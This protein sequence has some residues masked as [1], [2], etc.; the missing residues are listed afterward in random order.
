MRLEDFYNDHCT[1]GS[2][3]QC[4]VGVA[5]SLDDMHLRGFVHNDIKADNITVSGP[6]SCPS[7][8]IIDF[9]LAS[10]IGEGFYFDMLGLSRDLEDQKY[11]FF[12]SPELKMGQPLYPS[13]DVFSVGALLVSVCQE[14]Q[15]PGLAQCLT[16]LMVSCMQQV[17]SFRPSLATVAARVKEL[18]AIM[19]EDKLAAPLDCRY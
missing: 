14:M 17:P 7:V 6:P 18:M 4:V 19:T 12:R 13:S 15:N 11:V 1:V 3:L 2:F 8:H 9:G 10:R 16:P 5:E